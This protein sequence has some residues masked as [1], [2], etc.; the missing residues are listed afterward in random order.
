MRNNILSPRGVTDFLQVEK[1][2][3][4]DK[5]QSSFNV[6]DTDPTSPRKRTVALKSALKS[7][8]KGSNGKKLKVVKK[9]K[10]SS[11]ASAKSKEKKDKTKSQK[12]AKKKK[13]NAS[14]TVGFSVSSSDDE[15]LRSLKDAVEMVKRRMVD[16]EKR[17]QEDAIDF[18]ERLITAKKECKDKLEAV[19]KPL[20]TTH[21]KDGKEHQQKQMET[22]KLIDYIRDD[23]AKIRKEIEY[24]AREIKAMKR[25]NDQL[26]LANQKAADAHKELND[27]VDTMKAVNAKLTV[28]EKVFKEHLKAMKKDYLKRTQYHMCEVKSSNLYQTCLSKISTAVK[29][30]SRDA[31][32]IEELFTVAEAGATKALEEKSQKLPSVELSSLPL[33][34]GLDDM[35]QQGT[36]SFMVD[37][38]KKGNNFDDN[39]DDDS[40][41][42]DDC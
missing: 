3:V 13:A 11:G 28:N 14:S 18:K 32:F 19:Y 4:G 34:K 30:R 42:D 38:E 9:E 26:E 8:T 7:P 39:N 24:Y 16:L 41:S 17:K 40:D 10:S 2:K 12:A 21:V 15:T 37:E 23:N 29:D 31:T 22:N 20:I 36:W 25:S 35:S 27:H 1:S 6:A 33:P 5:L